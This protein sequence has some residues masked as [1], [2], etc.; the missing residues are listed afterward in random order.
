MKTSLISATIVSS[1]LLTPVTNA[2]TQ[3]NNQITEN[4]LT[5]AHKEE[6]GFGAGAIIGGILGGPAGALVTGL[7]S[8]FLMKN[9]NAE[10]EIDGLELSMSQNKQDHQTQLARLKQQMKHSEQEYQQEL[11]A[12][13]EKQNIENE[14]NISQLQAENLLMSFQFTTGS[15][16]IPEH[17]QE[18]LTALAEL[19]KLSP[20]LSIDLSGYTDLLGSSKRN[21]QLS[22][23]RANSVKTALTGLG[24]DQQRINTQAFG[25]SAP[26]VANAQKKSSFYDRRVMIKLHQQPSQVAKNY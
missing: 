15:S 7:A 25:E 11:L 5:A 19:L 4:T 16:D 10:E 23:A 13:S 18:Q 14:V 21:M 26:I 22:Q 6:I 24:I 2:N 9:I 12:M 3:N 17:Y 20:E 1:I 8:T